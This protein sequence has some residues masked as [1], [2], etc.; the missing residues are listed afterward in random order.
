[1]DSISDEKYLLQSHSFG[2]W[3]LCSPFSKTLFSTVTLSSLYFWSCPFLCYS[4]FCFL[5]FFT[6]SPTTIL[7]PLLSPPWAPQPEPLVSPTRA[8]SCCFVT[9]AGLS[10]WCATI[11]VP[12][13]LF[14][15]VHQPLWQ[16][17]T[18]LEYLMQI[19]FLAESQVP[20]LSQMTSPVQWL[21]RAALRVWGLCVFLCIL[22]SWGTMVAAG[23]V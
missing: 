12:R 21:S 16:K 10:Y 1:M 2:V 23:S 22:V 5:F 20:L 17:E 4:F 13:W 15:W 11:S 7:L 18:F 19:P 8:S 14:F 9:F 6:S 3:P